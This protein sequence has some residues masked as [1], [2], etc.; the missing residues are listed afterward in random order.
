MPNCNRM[1][2][3]WILTVRVRRARMGPRLPGRSH[4]PGQ[5]HATIGTHLAGAG[6]RLPLPMSCSEQP[7]RGFAPDEGRRLRETQAAPRSWR[8]PDCFGK[9]LSIAVGQAERVRGVCRPA[10]LY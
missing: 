6:V 4:A 7:R 10:H 2:P 9:L 5:Q 1:A 8:L 3:C